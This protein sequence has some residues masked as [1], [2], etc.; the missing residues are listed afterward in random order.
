[1]KMINN[2][3]EFGK[4]IN[5]PTNIIVIGLGTTGAQFV[6]NI[7][8]T[9]K[10]YGQGRIE[11]NQ[12]F[13]VMETNADELPPLTNIK[14]DNKITIIHP[15]LGALLVLDPDCPQ[16]AHVIGQGAACNRRAGLALY[17]YN[18]EVI[19]TNILK[20][21]TD[22][23]KDGG[24]PNF[25]II[26]VAGLF[27]GTGSS[28]IVELGLDIKDWLQQ[29]AT[30][31]S[32]TAIGILPRSIGAADIT[33]A[34]AIAALKEI[35]F[36]R[37]INT[38]LRIS[39]RTYQNPFDF[40]FLVSTEKVQGT[41]EKEAKEAVT[42]LLIDLGFIP[43]RE[44]DKRKATSLDW[45]NLLTFGQNSIGEFS[46]FSLW[47]V[48]LPIKEV[49]WV[50]NTEKEIAADKATLDN[51]QT[52]MNE[53]KEKINGVK[54][55]LETSTKSS[56]DTEQRIITLSQILSHGYPKLTKQLESHQATI[57][58]CKSSIT[59]AEKA[60]QIA[61][62]NIPDK[63]LDHTRLLLEKQELLR[64]STEQGLSLRQANEFSI[65]IP[66]AEEGLKKL[67]EQKTVLENQTLQQVC[68][69]LGQ[70]PDYTSAVTT[71]I[72][73][74]SLLSNAKTVLNYNMDPSIQTSG[75]NETTTNILTKWNVVETDPNTQIANLR[76]H[77]IGFA[78][79]CPSSVSRNIETVDNSMT[80]LV[81]YAK[82]VI[83]RGSELKHIDRSIW[84]YSIH[85]Y[86]LLL[87]LPL[88]ESDTKQTP[89]L[90]DLK[91]MN[92]AYENIKKESTDVI[93]KII[94]RHGFLFGDVNAFQKLTGISLAKCQTP[95]QRN[96]K[97]A[98]FWANYEIIE[99]RTKIDQIYLSLAS[100]ISQNQKYKNQIEALSNSIK[101][102]C[103]QDMPNKYDIISINEVLSTSKNLRQDLDKLDELISSLS[104]STIEGSDTL[105][106]QAKVMPLLIQRIS[107]DKSKHIKECSE[108]TLQSTENCEQMVISI[109]AINEIITNWLFSIQNYLANVPPN[110]TNI[111]DAVDKIVKNH[112][113]I[114]EKNLAI[115]PTTQQNSRTTLDMLKELI[116]AMIKTF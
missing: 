69:I 115:I 104:K 102:Q 26:L 35:S 76:R 96:Q 89:R 10:V 41:I 2:Q 33:N 80:P 12:T 91:F 75:L 92:P 109:S 27:G 37:G 51:T 54:Q 16:S 114:K 28:F 61:S 83:S 63:Q 55:D 36:I 39:S 97:I 100:V 79:I 47:S 20:V 70:A 34:N 30:Q 11:K 113:A 87:G 23:L 65:R 105:K 46:T 15:A 66:I 25:T 52:A 38:P 86:G 31:V 6:D 73:N 9:L 57:S 32:T 13:V 50:I 68:T 44:D 8:S 43:Y 1:M 99:P 42:K 93:E 24:T 62:N 22:L 88:Y 77:K 95:E 78:V 101:T 53:T 7:V 98:D 72:N 116:D 45:S 112:A 18:R 59:E 81:D 58:N 111:S 71:P 3:Q 17:R 5:Q 110:R 107:K 56:R 60:V 84:P 40:F 85:F 108:E 82:K 48:S 19:K 64:I 67:R 21:A 14:Q 94:A 29:V 4:L 74:F 49:E 103:N 106:D 90:L